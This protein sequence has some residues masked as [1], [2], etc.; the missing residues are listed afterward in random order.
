MQRSNESVPTD[1]YA[2]ATV[3][4]C[5][6]HA[7]QTRDDG[8]TPYSV[9]PVRVAEHLRRLAG[10]TDE[11]VLIAALLHDTIEDC[12]ITYETVAG[13]F[14]D[15]V[16]GLVAELT[17]DNR[18]PK[19]QRRAAMLDHLPALSPGAKKVK[20]SDRYDNVMDLLRTGG[21]A[22]KRARYVKETERLLLGCEGGCPAL[23]SA[24]RDALEQLTAHLNASV[25]A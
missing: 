23:E 12:G 15:A 7:K 2:R 17:N 14:G 11:A 21:T 25:S 13:Q 18:L 10:E 5:T 9:H 4:A 24:L 16:A 20:L 19:S 8:L 1:R 6:L 3:L 22:E